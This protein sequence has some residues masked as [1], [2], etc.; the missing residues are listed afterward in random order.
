MISPEQQY[1]IYSSEF[2]YENKL[3]APFKIYAQPGLSV[4][5]HSQDQA[6]A[7][8]LD[9]AGGLNAMYPFQPIAPY[10]GDNI[11]G[12]SLVGTADGRFYLIN[13]D[14]GNIYFT[15]LVNNPTLGNKGT[16]FESY[17]IEVVDGG[18]IRIMNSIVP[19]GFVM[20]SL[21]QALVTPP[22]PPPSPPPPPPPPPLPPPPSPPP[23]LPPYT[24]QRCVPSLWATATT[25][26]E[27]LSI[28]TCSTFDL[29]SGISNFLSFTDGACIEYCKCASLYHDINT[30]TVVAARS[31]SSNVCSCASSL[32]TCGLSDIGNLRI[33]NPTVS[34]T[35]P[36]Q[37]YKIY[38]S[39]VIN[40]NI[41]Y[42]P[43]KLY[44]SHLLSVT[45]H[46][47]ET[48]FS[49]YLGSGGGLYTMN[50]F[51]TIRPYAGS[52]VNGYSLIG[53]ADG[54]FGLVN[55]DTGILYF[56]FPLD[57]PTLG[58][59]GPFFQSYY[60]EVLEGDI[61]IMN[62]VIPGGYVMWSLTQMLATPPPPSPPPPAP[63][64]PQPP[65]SSSACIPT[66][67]DTV[68]TTP[69]LLTTGTC[70]IFDV[71]NGVIDFLAD[72]NSTC[73]EHCKC[74]ALYR[75]ISATN[76]IAA[77][78]PITKACRCASSLATC[79]I[80]YSGSFNIFNVAF[81]LVDPFQKY[82]IYSEQ[83]IIQTTFFAPFKLFVYPQLGGIFAHDFN[84]T[85]ALVFFPTGGLYTFDPSNEIVPYVGENTNGY[86]FVGTA[87][88]QFYIVSEDSGF[89]HYTFPTN[90]PTPGNKGTLFHSYYLE[91]QSNGNIILGNNIVPGGFVMWSLM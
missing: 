6:N 21:T 43:F 8:Y 49:L 77:H 47:P 52:N 40:Q 55:E 20:W 33:F 53:T 25:I 71:T 23:P 34:L 44:A 70:A 65:F 13:E 63:L 73:I 45:M 69:A 64:S 9:F 10:V 15:F 89:V 4:I 35:S 24:E 38:T 57:N 14:N 56:I 29:T 41:V 84:Q 67:W 81:S 82:T 91:I 16:L 42:A 30:D 18:D 5:L 54:Q 66:L 12:Y 36:V 1:R 27:L 50:P 79:N 7:L 11:N 31:P 88:G 59:E 90:N 19:G 68:G 60:L 75:S 72:N 46:A 39:E 74:S 48:V 80:N 28:G 37:K 85:T 86:S 17:Y 76:V 51:H 83:E 87:D 61:R 78:D 2:I 32:V 62:N 3:Y 26:P 22:P 58:Y